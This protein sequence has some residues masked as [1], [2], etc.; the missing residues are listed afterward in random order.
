MLGDPQLALQAL[1]DLVPENSKRE[2]PS[3]RR[4]P[5]K[6]SSDG[7]VLYADEVFSTLAESRPADTI[8][9]TETT[10]NV[11]E[12]LTVWAITAPGHIIRSQAAA[13]AGEL[14]LPWVSPWLSR[15]KESNG[16]WSL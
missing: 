3:S 15:P 14:P 11:T 10:S 2:W 6:V 12:L 13:W 7:D 16:R 1:I 5:L 8:L 4:P 9:L